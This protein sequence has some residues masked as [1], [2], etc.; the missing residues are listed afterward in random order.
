MSLPYDIVAARSRARLAGAIVIW[1]CARNRVRIWTR[2]G[3]LCPDDLN[4]DTGRERPGSPGLC[5]PRCAGGRVLTPPPPPFFSSAGGP[6]GTRRRPT[7]M[8]TQAQVLTAVRLRNQ[9]VSRGDDRAC[10]SAI[11]IPMVDGAAGPLAI[12]PPPR[13]PRVATMGADGSLQGK[14]EGASERVRLDEIG[15]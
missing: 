10:A 11:S 6:A 1:I 8:R 5:R 15:G 3:P 12:G 4:A 9:W 14:R 13:P 2:S 7:E